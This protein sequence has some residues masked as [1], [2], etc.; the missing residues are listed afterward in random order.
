MGKS[1]ESTQALRGLQNLILKSRLRQGPWERGVP[2]ETQ[3]FHLND[4]HSAKAEI[5]EEMG[6]GGRWRTK[7]KKKMCRA[8]ALRTK[9]IRGT[10]SQRRGRQARMGRYD[11]FSGQKEEVERTWLSKQMTQHYLP[12]VRRGEAGFRRQWSK[13]EVCGGSEPIQA[14][15]PPQTSSPAQNILMGHTPQGK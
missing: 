2:K 12:S 11:C 15:F 1:S 9:W 5:L 8:Q 14:T 3:E 4:G 10:A 6:E 13:R 7:M